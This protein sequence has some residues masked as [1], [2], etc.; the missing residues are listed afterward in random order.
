MK[1]LTALVS[2][3]V[4][5]SA[6]SLG[7]CKKDEKK[8]G[9][10][11]GKKVEPKKEEPKKEEPKAADPA[12]AGGGAAAATGLAECDA[13]IAAVEKFVTCDTV[14]QASRDATKQG[15]DGMKA[16][17]GDTAGMPEEAKKA[18][19]D[20]CKQATDALKQGASAMGCT[21]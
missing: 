16:A 2:V 10:T 15:L 9:D 8:E 1:K 17:W 13:Y 19:N 14:P 18:A 3:L 4:L 12:P 20:S 6:L 21:M 5:G 11:A 7:A